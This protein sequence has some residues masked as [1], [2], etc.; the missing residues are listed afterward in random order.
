MKKIELFIAIVLIVSCTKEGTE[1]Q[2]NNPF[3]LVG[4]WKSP[5]WG[6]K[7]GKFAIIGNDEFRFDS[8]GGYFVAS[9]FLLR[10]IYVTGNWTMNSTNDRVNFY[11]KCTSTDSLTKKATEELLINDREIWWDINFLNNDSLSVTEVVRFLRTTDPA[12]GVVKDTNY[13]FGSFPRSFTKVK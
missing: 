6:A 3:D 1:N 13:I 8:T 10:N 9:S 12:T 4:T 7:D 5:V 2:R 11:G